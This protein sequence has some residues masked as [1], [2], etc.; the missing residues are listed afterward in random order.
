MIDYASLGKSSVQALTAYS[1]KGRFYPSLCSSGVEHAYKAARPLAFLIGGRVNGE[2]LR[3]CIRYNVKMN[4]WEQ[5][6]SMVDARMK[7]SSCLL[8]DETL[9][10][11]CGSNENG[12]MKSIEKLRI[13]GSASF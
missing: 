9:Y 7:C 4:S 2:I 5:M 12:S 10:V 13:V 1:G 11:F 8:N 6:P 3:S